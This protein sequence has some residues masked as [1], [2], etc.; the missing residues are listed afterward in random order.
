MYNT[1]EQLLTRIDT[2]KEQIR[3]LFLKQ[4]MHGKQ[5]TS[6]DNPNVAACGQFL[7]VK[8]K[9]QRGL[10]GTAAAIRVL[11]VETGQETEAL[12]S[13]MVEYIKHR[14]SYEP[15]DQKKCQ[16]D[17]NNVVKIS[18]AFIALK[19]LK[20]ADTTVV[21]QF[22]NQ[23]RSGF[24]K[25]QGWSWFLDDQGDPEPYPTAF[26]CYAL[27][28]D[29]C[30][31]EVNKARQYLIEYLNQNDSRE[32][33][34]KRYVDTMT[35][36]FCLYVLTEVT[37][38][39]TSSEERNLFKPTFDRIWHR[40]EPLLGEDLEQNIEYGTCLEARHV[41]CAFPG[42]PICWLWLPNTGF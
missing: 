33:F 8:E 18:E 27:S 24:K 9:S 23:L 37:S 2:A 25:E 3:K 12:V 36:A 39:Q 5:T 38:G 35:D 34:Q 1:K 6:L 31:V 32:G 10:H 11:G 14:D 20:E 22:A 40:L 17:N 42:N 4:C 26:A 30:S 16:R 28:F 15:N 41:M 29:G 19:R 13:R 21:T 7:N